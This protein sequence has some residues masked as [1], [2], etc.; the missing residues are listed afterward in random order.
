MGDNK[1]RGDLVKKFLKITGLMLIF[2]LTA[3]TLSGCGK[4]CKN[5]VCLGEKVCTEISYLDGE[6]VSI[7]NAINDI[8]YFKYKVKSQEIKSATQGSQSMQSSG[9]E[10]GSNSDS[11]GNSGESSEEGEKSSEE[12]GSESSQSSQGS[13]SSSKQ[14]KGTEAFYMKSNNILG[15][16]KTENWDKIK[17]KVENLYISIPTILVDLEDSNI[18]KAQI[19]EFSKSLDE[20]AIATKNEDSSETLT[21]AIKVYEYLPKFA[22]EN[23]NNGN[24]NVLSS[25][26]YLLMCYKN[27]NEENWEEYKKSATDLKMNF[28]N[29]LN[30]RNMYEQKDI[31]IDDAE[32]I[33]N[34]IASI[35]SGLEK[36][37]FFLKYR[38]LMQELDML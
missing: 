10:Q 7:I 16:D 12:G 22:K 25:K 24:S 30:N 2:T 1:L 3:S 32:V 15:V 34:E 23:G 29:I 4:G 35:D 8:D 28:S 9:G 18:D 13:S 19:A 36:D 17:S 11:G 38:N 27:A 6:L 31:N 37:V 20:L 5:K 14:S 21:S 33:I 26:Y